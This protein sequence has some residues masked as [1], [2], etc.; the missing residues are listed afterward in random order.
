M[1]YSIEQICLK[2]IHKAQNNAKDSNGLKH[3][4]EYR[5][6]VCLMENTVFCKVKIVFNYI[7]QCIL[8]FDSGFLSD[9]QHLC[10]LH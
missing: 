4:H 1:P 5:Q 2:V 3:G 6:Q 7:G 8:I 9:T 10:T